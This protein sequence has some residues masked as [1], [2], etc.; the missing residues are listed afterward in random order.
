MNESEVNSFC[1]HMFCWLVTGIIAAILVFGLDFDSCMKIPDW[2]VSE[3]GSVIICEVEA[4]D[5]M[6]MME[7]VD[8]SYFAVPN[9]IF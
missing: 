3:F 8:T 1:A 6:R 9:T 7:I 4:V 2:L 5:G